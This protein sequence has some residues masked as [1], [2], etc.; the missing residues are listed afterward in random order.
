VSRP[1]GEIVVLGLGNILLGDDAVGVHV[2]RQLTTDPSPD[3]AR[4]NIVD[5]GTLGLDLLPLVDEAR[6]LLLIDAVELG[7]PP[8]TVVVLRGEDLHARLDRA[9]TAH[10]AGLGDLV[11][12]ARLIGTLPERTSLV[13]VQPA[14]VAVGLELSAAVAE[15]LPDA[16]RLAREEIAA[17]A[18]PGG[19]GAVQGEPASVGDHGVQ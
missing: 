18:A 14:S 16:V 3:A 4:A 19:L 15:A 11:A 7:A 5:G 9:T 12:A 10:Q 2:V 8:G 1:D 6:A 17:M 13:A